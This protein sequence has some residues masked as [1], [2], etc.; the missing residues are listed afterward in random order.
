M[1]SPFWQTAAHFISGKLMIERGE[2]AQGVAVL[3]DAFDASRQ[4]GWRTSFPEFKGALA[5]GFAG[6]GQLDEALAAANEGLGG[7][8]QGERGHDLYFAELLRIK[9]DILFRRQ[10]VTEAE[11]SFREALAVAQRQEALLW[12]LRAALSLARLLVARTATAKRNEFW[13]QSMIA[14]PRAS[15]RPI[16]A[17]RRRSWTNFGG[18]GHASRPG[19]VRPR[20]TR[21]MEPLPVMDATPCDARTRA[22]ECTEDGH[23]QAD[24]GIANKRNRPFFERFDFNRLQNSD[25]QGLLNLGAALGF[26]IREGSRHVGSD[27]PNAVAPVASRAILPPPCRIATPKLV[28]NKVDL[29]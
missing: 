14:S 28:A 1:N 8:V 10:D 2:F 11:D 3:N 25:A 9:G 15:T 13:R 26:R 5:T 16:F 27:F 12:E 23:L 21:L 22:T 29:R 20:L 7:A 6:L 19:Q 18:D 4:N 24:G 17:P